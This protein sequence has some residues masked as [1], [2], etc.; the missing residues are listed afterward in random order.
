MVTKPATFRRLSS[1]WP[2][3]LSNVVSYQSFWEFLG[4]AQVSFRFLPRHTIQHMTIRRDTWYDGW[5]NRTRQLTMRYDMWQREKCR[6]FVCKI[7]DKLILRVMLLSCR[8]AANWRASTIRATES[9]HLIRQMIIATRRM[10]MR[11]DIWNVVAQPSCT[12]SLHFLPRY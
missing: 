12:S 8:V 7:I 2:I 1:V 6:V 10:P 11:R 9:W 4:M 5:Q 3:A